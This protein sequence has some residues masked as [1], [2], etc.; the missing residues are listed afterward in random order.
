MGRKEGWLKR[1]S[2]KLRSRK[3]RE[4][5]KEEGEEG[6]EMTRDQK[7]RKKVQLYK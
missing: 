6:R 7:E 5:K 1:L 4:K 3:E 2:T